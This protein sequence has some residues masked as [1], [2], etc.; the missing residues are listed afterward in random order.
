MLGGDLDEV[1]EALANDERSRQLD[2]GELE[3]GVTVTAD[4]GTVTWRAL[5]AETA[6]RLGSVDEARWIA[7][8]RRRA[9]TS[10][11]GRSGSTTP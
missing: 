6:A 8:D 9:G 5:L 2:E 3:Q 7:Q 10:P 4:G 11:S 1:V